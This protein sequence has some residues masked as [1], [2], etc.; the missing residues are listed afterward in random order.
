[1]EEEMKLDWKETIHDL[2]YAHMASNLDEIYV[3]ADKIEQHAHEWNELQRFTAMCVVNATI[4][5]LTTE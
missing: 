3:I 2:Y 5:S 1:M 4:Q